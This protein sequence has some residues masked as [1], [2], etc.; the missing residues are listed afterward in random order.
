MVEEAEEVCAKCSA[1]SGISLDQV[2]QKE[3]AIYE[4]YSQRLAHAIHQGVDIEALKQEISSTVAERGSRTISSSRSGLRSGDNPGQHLANA[5]GILKDEAEGLKQA[6]TR[7][8][9]WS[10]TAGSNCSGAGYG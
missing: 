5:M 1:D 8:Q 3:Y 9:G 6:A 4:E 2:A 7:G 10:C